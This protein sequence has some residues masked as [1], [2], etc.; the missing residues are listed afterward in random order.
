ML[1]GDYEGVGGYASGAA[2]AVCA[3][4]AEG[5]EGCEGGGGYGDLFGGLLEGVRRRGVRRGLYLDF[6]AEAAA[7]CCG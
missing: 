3:V 5:W 6:P 7:G 2:F 4:A 1:R